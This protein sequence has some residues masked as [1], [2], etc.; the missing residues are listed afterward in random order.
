MNRDDELNAAIDNCRRI[1]AEQVS[2]NDSKHNM[3]RV[4][5]WLV[6]TLKE[7]QNRANEN[8]ITSTEVKQED[9]CPEVHE[10]TIND[11]IGSTN[12]GQTHSI[13]P[14]N[15]S[16][17]GDEQNL[18]VNVLENTKEIDSITL[19][20][21]TEPTVI[22]ETQQNAADPIINSENI[23]SKN[24]MPSAKLESYE[25]VSTVPIRLQLEARLSSL[26]PIDVDANEDQHN[27][28]AITNSRG[29]RISRK[30]RNNVPSS[31]S[32]YLKRSARK[33]VMN[34]LN[35]TSDE[36]DE[37]EH[38]PVSKKA[39]RKPGVLRNKQSQS[40]LGNAFHLKANSFESPENMY[41]LY[42]ENTQYTNW[43]KMD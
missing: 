28:L 25:N 15:D 31:E 39:C 22:V 33:S 16:F 43:V 11:T 34:E 29:P 30:K 6:D 7:T 32:R 13:Q 3:C 41:H 40:E 10:S 1:S 27:C 35:H 24:A 26:V 37:N 14:D 8:E 12:N 18:N 20:P 36:Y 19:A 17:R 4:I 38:T 9:S 23:S 5:T 42:N 21:T 2:L